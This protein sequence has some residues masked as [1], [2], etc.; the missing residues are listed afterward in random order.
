MIPERPPTQVRMVSEEVLLTIEGREQE[1][2]DSHLASDFMAGHVEATFVMRNQG[3]EL[4]S[5]DVWFPL[6]TSDGFGSSNQVQNFGAWVDE[7][8][9]EVSESTGRDLLD[10][11][12]SVPWATWPVTFPPGQDTILRVTYDVLPIGYRPFGDFHYILETGADWQDTIGEATVTI[13]LPYPVTPENTTL[14]PAVSHHAP[15]P[16]GFQVQD[17]EVVWRFTNLEPTSDDNVRLNVL[18]PDR[19]QALVAAREAVVAA[20]DSAEAQLELARAARGAVSM[21]HGVNP[22]GGGDALA[23]VASDAYVRSLKLDPQQ[24]EIYGEYAEWLLWTSNRYLSEN[25]TYPEALY[26]AVARGLERLPDDE[27]LLEIQE[28]IAS[29]EA[30]STATPTLRPTLPSPTPVPTTPPLPSPTAAPTATPVPGNSSAPGGSLCT[31]T[32]LWGLIPLAL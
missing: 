4:E 30:Q 22:F 27:R 28:I 16:D 14:D 3:A 2:D 25:G 1:T 24:N 12:E 32:L 7:V 10:F 8:P 29:Q 15:H 31:G 18:E 13:R 20:P 17:N 23:Q 9:V 5:F 11:E 26:D 21:K 19:W 6:T